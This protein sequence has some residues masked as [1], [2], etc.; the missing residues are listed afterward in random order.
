MFTDQELYFIGAK[1]YELGGNFYWRL[2]GKQLA[3]SSSAWK[4][5]QPNNPADPVICTYIRDFEIHDGGCHGSSNIRC[6]CEFP[7][8]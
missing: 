2:S 6:L 5:D 3:T 7:L 1:R 4:S 8:Y